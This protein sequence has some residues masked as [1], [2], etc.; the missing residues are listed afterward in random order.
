M[1][2]NIVGFV[3]VIVLILNFP[4]KGTSLDSL[5]TEYRDGKAFI[6]HMV[7]GGETLYAIS[8]R[9]NCSMNSIAQATPEVKRGL[10]DGMLLY[11]PYEPNKKPQIAGQTLH[12]VAKGETLYSISRIYNISVIEIMEWN[13][14]LSSDLEV[15]QELK[16]KGEAANQPVNYELDGMKIHVVQ[17]GEGLYAIARNYNISVDQL[18]EWNELSASS[19]NLGQ[20]LIVGMIGQE[21]VP[22]DE[23]TTE[24]QNND[25]V[26]VAAEVVVEEIVETKAEYGPPMPMAK[27]KEDGLASAIEGGTDD[28]TYLA[29]HRTIPIGS[30]VSVR[31]EMNNQVVFAR[32]VGKLPDTGV[33]NKIIIRLSKAAVEQLKAIDP[34]FRVEVTYL[35]PEN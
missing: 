1:S 11:I 30:L 6:V 5:R 21:V 23:P 35:V 26:V 33:N 22:E 9:Y 4:V 16:I 14:L 3:V 29:M 13:D 18:V 28:N 27:V 10:H 24:T 15:G 17:P 34:K 32:V 12:M 7:D 19:L 31:N 25:E 2:R 20:E 8:K